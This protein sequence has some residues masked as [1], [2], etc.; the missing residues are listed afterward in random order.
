MKKTIDQIEEKN[1]LLRSIGG[2]GTE[3]LPGM[4]ELWKKFELMLDSH[5][6]MIKEQV[7]HLN[8]ILT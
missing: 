1:V 5:Q 6:L 7:Y 2:S 8:H 4:L 3:Q